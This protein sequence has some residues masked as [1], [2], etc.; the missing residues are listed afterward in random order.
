MVA[1]E[2]AHADAPPSSERVLPPIAELALASMALI[3]IGGIYMASHIPQ[4]VPLLPAIVL[5]AAAG[6][7]LVA[8]VL[9]LIRVRQ[10]AW[11][12]FSQVFRWALLAY[13]IIAGMIGYAFVVDGTKGRALAVL[14]LMLVVFAADI[15]L[16]LA[17]SVARY[18]EA[19]LGGG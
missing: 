17:F 15:P 12:R 19:G 11:D 16:L 5:L 2:H 8:D 13:V 10:F 1:G 4:S 14:L 18:A 6:V 9:I 3:V 7:L